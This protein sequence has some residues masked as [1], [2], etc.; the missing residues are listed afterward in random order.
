MHIARV[1]LAAAA[2]MLGGA[3][4]AQSY[5]TKP[6]KVL[7][8]FAPGGAPD[9][10]LRRIASKLE[11]RLGQPVVV[12]NRA[13]ASGWELGTDAKAKADTDY[14][15]RTGD[16]RGLIPISTT[17]IFVTPRVWTKKD[18]WAAARRGE[19]ASMT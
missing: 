12:E 1:I 6:V 3:A 10:V 11:E 13:G 18:D 5:P 2:L 16:P 9:T 15:K 19:T 4:L 7:I 8:G 14:K 17:F